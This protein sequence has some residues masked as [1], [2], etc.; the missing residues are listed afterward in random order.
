[1]VVANR[2]R[3]LPARVVGRKIG[4]G[5]RIELLLLR[6]VDDRTWEAL[7]GGRRAAAGQRVEIA[8]DLVLEL[9]ETTSAGRLVRF[10]DEHDPVEVLHRWGQ[11]PLPPY[12]HGYAGDPERYQTVYAGEDGSAAAP[13]AG[14]HFTPDLLGR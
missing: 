14:L 13:T 8:P 1:L 12:I 5:G 4:S 10:P 9:G 2:S 7:I 3:V 11:A 6:P